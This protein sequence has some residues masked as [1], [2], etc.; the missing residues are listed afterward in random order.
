MYFAGV[1][2]NANNGL[3]RMCTNVWELMN[4]YKVVNALVLFFT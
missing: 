4:I 3:R 1:K 2:A